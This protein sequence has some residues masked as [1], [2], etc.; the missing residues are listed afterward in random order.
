MVNFSNSLAYTRVPQYH[1]AVKEILAEILQQTGNLPNLLHIHN[2]N[3][4][5]L[6]TASIGN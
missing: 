3:R 4:N 1:A 5:S 2:G 6:E